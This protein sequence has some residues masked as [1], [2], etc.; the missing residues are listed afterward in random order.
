MEEFLC[1]T[2]ELE[3]F[4]LWEAWTTCLFSGNWLVCAF[5]CFLGSVLVNHRNSF[6]LSWCQ[7]GEI[8]L[9]L[10]VT[11]FIK[12]LDLVVQYSPCVFIYVYLSCMYKVSLSFW[13]CL[14]IF[15]L[16]LV[17]GLSYFSNRAAL[18]NCFKSFFKKIILFSNPISAF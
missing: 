16:W 6:P 2:F 9:S 11:H 5:C 13:S 17:N 7:F 15:L 12:V 14:V 1:K 3:S 18:K 8:R 4:V 10:Y